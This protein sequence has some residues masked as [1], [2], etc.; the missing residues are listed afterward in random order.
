MLFRLVRP[1]KRPGT[2]MGH[3]VQRIPADVKTRATGRKLLMPV[4]GASVPITVK[5]QADAIR[6][7]LRTRDPT[8]TKVRQARKWRHTWETVWQALR[9]SGAIALTH[10][11]ATAL[12]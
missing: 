6:L 2:T 1:L 4:G 9:A 3:F 5:P 10:S 12:D 8:E 11:Q 7:S